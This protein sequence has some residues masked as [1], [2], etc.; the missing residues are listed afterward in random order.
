MRGILLINKEKGY[1][2]RDVVNIISNHLSLKKVGH[3]GTLDPLASGLLV[4]CLG[5]AT[6][7]VELITN[8]D[9][10]YLATVVLGLHS[11]TLDITG[12]LL[13]KEPC[14]ISREEIEKGLEKMIGSYEQEVPLYSAVRIKGKRLWEYAKKEEAVVLPKRTVYLKNLSLVDEPNYI[15]ETVVFKVKCLVSK[16]TYIRSLIRD[17]AHNLGT[18]GLMSDL[19]RTQQGPFLIEDSITLAEFKKGNYQLKPLL[20][21]LK[22]YK[23]VIVE[24]E[25]EKMISN[26]KILPNIYDEE[27]ILFLNMKKE[28]LA[29]YKRYSKDKKKIKPWKMFV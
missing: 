10:E 11:D 12:N 2:S 15:N 23:Q 21:G 28:P 1:T 14:F 22:E 13:K 19:I 7:I 18:I 8:N 4:I 24:G 26:G 25:R 6:K 16:G 27:L 29:L 20:E 9:K 3:T 5:K 17:L